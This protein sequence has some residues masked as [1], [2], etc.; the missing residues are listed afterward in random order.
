MAQRAPIP[1][2]APANRSQNLESAPDERCASRTGYEQIGA[3]GLMRCVA[4]KTA[5]IFTTGLG[6]DRAAVNP[7]SRSTIGD[8]SKI[9][10]NTRDIEKVQ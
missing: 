9:D 8:A 4:G 6:D 3:S 2:G 10:T 1:S 7:Y 5:R